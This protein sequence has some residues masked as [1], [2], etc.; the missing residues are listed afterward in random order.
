[1]LTRF[2]VR[3]HFVGLGF[4][5]R[6]GSQARL[7]HHSATHSKKAG[8]KAAK[9]KKADEEEIIEL[10]DVKGY[11]QQ[12][13]DHFDKTIEL[14]K[15]NL[16]EVKSGASNPAIFDKLKVG[17][18]GSKFT[19]LATTSTKGRNGLIVTVFDPKDTKL[20]VSTILAAGLNLNPERI[21]N[22]EQQLK[23]SLP[24][25]TTETRKQTCK[26][27]KEIFEEYKNSANKNSLGHA[28][29]EILKELKK[30]DKKNDSVKKITQDLEKLHKDYITKLQDSLKQA[31]KSVLG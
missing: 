23:I 21:P 30:I 6:L 22:N 26:Q 4:Q 1:M 15:K 13:T 27:L 11:I 28:R 24:P 8:K 31:E 7:F 17:K 12:A 25:P 5:A 2:A 16:N 14:H 18:D 10:I 20:I 19:D 29:S 3:T 9:G